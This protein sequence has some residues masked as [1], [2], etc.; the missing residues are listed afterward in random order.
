MYVAVKGGER[1]IEASWRLLDKSRRGDT[2]VPE[3]SVTQIREQ[4]P[5]REAGGRGPVR[6]VHGQ[7]GLAHPRRAHHHRDGGAARAAV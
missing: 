7:R 1:A 6:P 5:V 4:L 3:L 2:S